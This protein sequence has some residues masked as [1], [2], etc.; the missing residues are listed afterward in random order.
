MVRCLSTSSVSGSRQTC[1]RRRVTNFTHCRIVWYKTYLRFGLNV[2]YIV[3]YI[4]IVV[5]RHTCNRLTSRKKSSLGKD[6]RRVLRP[7]DSGYCHLVCS[8]C[9]L[10][11]HRRWSCS[12]GIEESGRQILSGQAQTGGAEHEAEADG[13]GK[14]LLW[15]ATA[16]SF[17]LL[18]LSLF[19]SRL[20]SRSPQWPLSQMPT[21][22]PPRLTWWRQQNAA[23]HSSRC[24]TWRLPHQFQSHSSQHRIPWICLPLSSSLCSLVPISSSLELSPTPSP[25]G[26][27]STSWCS[28]HTLTFFFPFPKRRGSAEFGFSQIFSIKSGARS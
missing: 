4:V 14:T 27:H 25:R 2:L 8:L 3:N 18:F 28:I 5:R 24:V 15:L 1:L 17:L 9:R 16:P 7:H 13:R 11:V 20:S 23:G 12:F 6:G 21:H 26:S 10:I 22:S 19:L